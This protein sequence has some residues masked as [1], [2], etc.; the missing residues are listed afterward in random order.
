MSFP[1]IVFSI[2]GEEQEQS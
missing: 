2:F 1:W